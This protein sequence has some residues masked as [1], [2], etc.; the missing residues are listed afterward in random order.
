MLNKQI[1]E[2]LL[3]AM[4]AKDAVS[5][6]VLRMLKS[7]LENKKIEK[8]IAKDQDLPDA[9]CVAVI[10]SELKK[11]KDSIDAYTEA[12]RND[13]V[14]QEQAEAA[15]LE[16]YLP[17]Q[18]SEDQVVA[19]VQEV[20]KTTGAESPSDFGKVIGQVMAKTKGQADGQLVSK[21]VKEE[22]NKKS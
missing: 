15:I 3:S 13:L 12:K 6:S 16:K 22:L 18:M 7:A 10:K 8:K 2:D 17:E 21:V 1:Q 19:I 14:E 20:I 11:R 9:D 5:V 4:K